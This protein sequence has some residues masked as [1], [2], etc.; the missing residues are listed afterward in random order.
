MVAHDYNRS[1]G[2]GGRDRKLPQVQETQNK[3]Q[4]SL[5]MKWGPVSIK[6]KPSKQKPLSFTGKHHCGNRQCSWG[7]D[8]MLPSSCWISLPMKGRSL[9]FDG[10]R[11]KIHHQIRIIKLKKNTSQALPYY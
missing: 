2:E 9:L 10:G 4:V 11:L 5:V 8:P 6:L 1:T 3:N 7:L